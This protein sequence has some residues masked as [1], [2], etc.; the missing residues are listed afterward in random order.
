MRFELSG[1]AIDWEAV[2]SGGGIV[3]GAAVVLA[4]RRDEKVVLVFGPGPETMDLS[5]DPPRV[6]IDRARYRDFL[7]TLHHARVECADIEVRVNP[8]PP[9]HVTLAAVF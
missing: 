9:A 4:G 6:T 2:E 5:A 7:D 8:G 1:Y 3:S